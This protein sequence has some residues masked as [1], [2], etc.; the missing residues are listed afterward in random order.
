MTFRSI[1]ALILLQALILAGPVWAV[2]EE[3]VPQNEAEE[4]RI[5]LGL[6]VAESRYDEAIVMGRELIE[7]A[8][9]QHGADSLEEALILDGLV[10]ALYRSGHAMEE[11]T[12]ELAAR[13]VELKELHLGADAVGV[14]VSL[15]HSGNIHIYRSENA[16]AR[17][18]Y[19]RALQIFE[20][21]G[22]RTSPRYGI[23]LNN[24]GVTWK[25]SGDF[26]KALEIYETSLALREE[27]R[28]PD[29]PD[30]AS[31]LNNIANVL[32]HLGDYAGAIE[33]NRRA[34]SI[35]EAYYG[36]MNDWVAESLNNLATVLGYAGEYEEALEVQER[37]VEVFAETLGPDHERYWAGQSNLAILYSDMGD[38]GGARTIHV[39]VLE[40]QERKYGP[41]H[42]DLIDTLN[43]LA[44]CLSAL[45]GFTES[46]ELFRRSLAISE[47]AYGVGN[48]WTAYPLKE[49]GECLV[50]QER[51]EEAAEYLSRALMV[52]ESAVD[53]DSPELCEFLHSLA[54]LELSRGEYNAARELAGSSVSIVEASLGGDHPLLA[55][56]LILAAQA[57]YGLG[58]ESLAL[59]QALQAETISRRHLRA[60]M[61]V[62]SEH[63][64]LDYGSSRITGLDLALAMLSDGEESARVAAVWDQVIRSRALV[65][66][67]MAAR[68][69]SLA[70]SDDAA[71]AALVEELRS[72]QARL[73]H[74]SL[75]GPGWEELSAYRLMLAQAQEQKEAAERSLALASRRFRDAEELQSDGLT[76]VVAALDKDDQ[77]LAFVR[78]GSDPEQARYAAFALDGADAVPHF[79][80]L[81]SAAEVDEIVDRWHQ[82]AAYGARV[83]APGE[84][85]RGFVKRA[86]DPQLQQEAYDEVAR[87]LRLRVWDSAFPGK[88]KA[89]RRYV[90]SD[91]SLHLVNYYALVEEDGAYVLESGPLLRLLPTERSLCVQAQKNPE[92]PRLLVVGDPIYTPRNATARDADT[93]CLTLE[94]LNF[95]ALQGARQ[96]AEEITELWSR[97]E[98]TAP[99]PKLLLGA[100]AT[101]EAIKLEAQ[102]CEFLHLATHGFLISSHCT[103]GQGHSGANPNPLL[104]SGLALAVSDQSSGGSV[105]Q[106]D[107]LLTAEEVAG[108]DLSGL[109]WAVL[110]AC[111]TGLGEIREQGEG[112]FGLSRSFQIA[113]A[114][115]VV[116][117]LWAVDDAA[118]RRWMRGLYEAR[119]A[120]GND[121]AEAIREASLQAL[122]QLR[123]S[124]DGE[125]PYYW[126]GFVAL[127]NGK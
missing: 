50:K 40:N 30:V 109:D 33:C 51:Y 93:D 121:T 126:A 69:R 94:D 47:Q 110:S 1:F 123:A 25:R 54:E 83:S 55:A 116:M 53:P 98:G 60:T 89:A 49:L 56:A 37:A 24:L 96:E 76:E 52:Q 58:D 75:R 22:E 62:L 6:L 63:L 111:D 41:N 125:H 104:R 11:E 71:T 91:G 81:G 77:L 16:E 74:L 27:V 103:G 45:G 19:L 3:S 12:V 5:A 120:Q 118:T 18:D 108:L 80:D 67:E 14:A 48:P 102:D 127:G 35:R 28:G 36:P 106:E 9:I 88:E 23:A 113:G 84:Q 31:S 70:E 107:G 95:E 7:Q 90:V 44:V 73:A 64:A 87:E 34:L 15:L 78:H 117:S 61:G 119:F 8:R 21:A 59:D 42:P 66:D 46:E 99:R 92:L 124:D 68:G 17:A 43:G 4:A 86:R 85:S 101:E 39:E 79:V 122:Q 72:A 38:Y 20:D 32:I 2:D 26:Q 57:A 112:V 100:E 114:R 29:H 115:T 82:Q 10:E 97:A 65:L 105:G 13:A